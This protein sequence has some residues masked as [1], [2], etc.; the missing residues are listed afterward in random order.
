MVKEKRYAGADNSTPSVPQY[1]SWINSTN[2]GST[3]KQTLINLDY[4]RYMKETYGMQIRLYAWDAGNFDGASQGYGDV[5][6]E[7]FRSQY[8]E[9]YKNIV[10]KAGEIGIR[11]GLWGS[12]DGF[13]DDEETEKKRF[14]FFVHLCRDYHFGQFKIDG[15]CGGLR[16]E[17]AELYAK[18]LEECRKYS[19]DLIVLNHRLPLYEAEKYVTTFLWKGEETYTDVFAHNRI[20]GMHNRCYTFER[21]H[22]DGLERLAE[23]H[24]VCL[25][26]ALDYFEDDLIYQ[27]FSRC[28]I[29][30][31]EIYGNPWLL[32]DSEQPRLA[33]IYNLHGRNADIL[34]NGILLGNEYGCNAV[35]RGNG[36]KRFICTGNDTWDIKKISITIDGSVGITEKGKYRVALRHPYDTVL[37]DGLEYGSKIEVVLMPFRATL[38]EIVRRDIAEP[39][40]CDSVYEVIK[41]NADG[42]PAEYRIVETP[43]KS[44]VYLGCLDSTENE[45]DDGE[46][47]YESAMFAINNDSLESR[48]L[49]RAGNTEVPEIQAARDAFFGQRTYFLRGCEASAM[50]DGREDT[51]YDSQSRSYQNHSL[52]IANGCL[53]VDFG[54]I[55][56][57][58]YVEI[59]AF[60]ADE[61]TVEV[62]AQLMPDFA[63]FSEDLRAWNR[64]SKA[65]ISELCRYTQDVVKFGVH[66]IYPL[67]GKKLRFVYRCTENNFRYMRIPEPMDRIYSVKAY[68]NGEE[69]KLTGQTANDIQAPYYAS[70]TKFKKCASVIIPEYREESRIAVAINGYHG[71]EGVF[72]TVEYDGNVKGF[73]FRAPEY[74]ANMWEHLVCSEDYNNTFYFP[75]PEGMAGKTAKI[76]AVFSRAEAIDTDCRVYLCDRHE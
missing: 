22:V 47:N 19:P 67:E 29:L 43:E 46:F 31:P 71:N 50:F 69:I 24:G 49:K 25:S 76:T 58:D 32:K 40:L 75:L 60:A 39:M 7:K 64:S 4:F 35:S 33:R 3:E 74:K 41:E 11:M 26:S 18:M 8:P 44:P 52:R 63:E 48:C 5:N 53:R 68:K 66:T 45:P 27:A 55:I 51:F 12:P 20:T 16:P 28:L 14:E 65:E 54:K 70:K 9:G 10:K 37:S 42:S 13:G 2:E 6:S 56:D 59:V 38:I 73:P 23:D 17:K 15:V 62:P 36:I 1:F 30:A 21:G 57:A 61:P 72:C 34:V